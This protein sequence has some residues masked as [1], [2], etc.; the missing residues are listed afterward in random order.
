VNN[1]FHQTQPRESLHLSISRSEL[2]NSSA[3]NSHP[4]PGASHA[5]PAMM[6]YRLRTFH[7]KSTLPPPSLPHPLPPRSSPPI[8]SS[9]SIMTTEFPRITHMPSRTFSLLGFCSVA[10]S[11]TMLRKT[12]FPRVVSR[13]LRGG[14]VGRARERHTSYPLSVPMTLRE[15]LSWTSTRLS[16]YCEARV[17]LA[18]GF[19]KWTF[20]ETYLFELGLCLRHRD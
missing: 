17:A 1:G 15:P 2:L 5:L 19:R 14:T 12:F 20:G 16:R 4:T 7:E 3:A 13:L 18:V 10:S 6:M 11:R 8:L 9:A